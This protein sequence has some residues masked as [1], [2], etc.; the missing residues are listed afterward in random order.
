MAKLKES[1]EKMEKR[2]RSRG[3]GGGHAGPVPGQNPDEAPGEINMRHFGHVRKTTNALHGSD[4][5]KAS[6]KL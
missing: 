3:A 4:P 6:H 5:Y 2:P 1:A